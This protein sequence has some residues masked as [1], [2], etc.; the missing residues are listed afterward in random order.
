MKKNRIENIM[1]AI[2]VLAAIGG[3]VFF[4][5]NLAIGFVLLVLMALMFISVVFFSFW[6]HRNEDNLSQPRNVSRWAILTTGF[7]AVVTMGSYF[8]PSSKKIYSNNDHHAIA[9]EGLETNQSSLL[10]AANS[11][12]ALFDN[13]TLEGSIELK[14]ISTDDSTATLVM[15]G[16]GQPVFSIKFYKKNYFIALE[17]QEHLHQFDASEGL[18]LIGIDGNTVARL[19]I[20]YFKKWEKLKKRWK[21]NYILEYLGADGIMHADTSAYN[22]VILKR[23]SLASLFPGIEAVHGVDFS[24]IDLVRSKTTLNN[25]IK[26][27]EAKDYPF[28]VAYNSGSGLSALRSGDKT[29]QIGRRTSLKIKLDNSAYAIGLDNTIPQFRLCSDTTG[30]ASVRFRMPQYRYL[31]TE[32]LKE[33]EDDYFTFMV[34]STLIDDAGNINEQL[35][36]N[37]LLY[38]MFDHVDNG[39]QMRPMYMSFH[40]GNTR[41][42]LQVKV[43]DENGNDINVKAGENM[44][45]IATKGGLARWIVSLDNFKDPTLQRPYLIKSPLSAKKMLLYIIAFTLVCYF[46]MLINYHERTSYM[47]PMVYI[48]IITLLAIRLM[49]MWRISVFPPTNG[50]TLEEFNSWRTAGGLISKITQCIIFFPLA[51]L[52]YKLLLLNKRTAQN[53]IFERWNTDENNFWHLLFPLKAKRHWT[54]V[55]MILAWFVV[56][57]LGKLLLTRPWFCVGFTVIYYFVVDYLIHKWLGSRATDESNNSYSFFWHSLINSIF[58]SGAMLI[59]DGGYGIMFLIFTMLLIGTRLIDLYGAN[60]YDKIS[61]A[62]IHVYGV[63]IMLIIVTLILV[64]IRPVI[65][66]IYI[67]GTS[68]IVVAAVATAA[69]CTLIT[70]TVGGFRRFVKQSFIVI[71][72][73]AAIASGV[74]YVM[75]NYG[76]DH[77]ANRAK[78]LEYE[79]DKILGQ[80]SSTKD[81]QKFLEAS[82]ND[83]VLEEYEERGHDMAAFIG[84]KGEGYFKI[85]PHSKVGVSWMTQ[86][87]DLSVSRFMIA[88]QSSALPIL[89]IA[90]FALLTLFSMLVPA[91]RRWARSLLVQIPLLLTTQSLFVWMAVTRRFIFMGQDFPMI[92]IISRVN[93]YMCFIG[94]LVWICVAMSERYFLHLQEDRISQELANG[95]TKNEIYRFQIRFS[96]I[97][98]AFLVI[99]GFL[100]VLFSQIKGRHTENTYNVKD[101][102][103]AAYNLIAHPDKNSVEALFLEYQD[104]LISATNDSLNTH[105]RIHDITKLGNHIAIVKSFCRHLNYTPGQINTSGLIDR[106]FDSDPTYGTF[107]KA[108]FDHY[109]EKQ[110]IHNDIDDF[111]YVVKYRYTDEEDPKIENVRYVFDLYTRIYVQNLPTRLEHSWRGSILSNSTVCDSVPM[112]ARE[113]GTSIY[114]LPSNWIKRHSL[115]VRP[116]SARLSVV[117]K[118]EPRHLA[119]GEAYNLT[120]GETL[121]GRGAPDLTKYGSGNYIARNV[122][123]NS[124]A[125]FIYPLQSY[126]YWANPIS[127]QLK[128]YMNA[129]LA[130]EKFHNKDN[131]NKSIELTISASLTKN[132]YQEINN[133]GRTNG[134]VAVVVADGNGYVRALIDHKKKEYDINPNDSRRIQQVE[135]SLKREGMLNRGLEAQR[136]FGNKAILSL[137]NGPG[138]SQKPLVWTAVTTQYYTGWDWNNLQLAKINNSLM[139]HGEK[140]NALSWAG[141]RID[142]RKKVAN[143]TERGMFRSITGDEG[144]GTSNV[145]IQS[146]MKYSSN[147]YNA[148]MTH[149]GSF[150]REE[151]DIGTPQSN[152]IFKRSNESWTTDNRDDHKTIY[153]DS[154]FPLMIYDNSYLIFTNP[155]DSR[156]ATEQEAV[157]VKGLRDNF[158]LPTEYHKRDSNTQNTFHPFLTGK[159]RNHYAYPEISF[160]NNKIRNGLPFEIAR[161]GVKMTAIGK[162]SVWLV[163]PFTMAEMYG[164]MI[165]FNRN[166]RLTI[167]SNSPVPPYSE[168]VTED[169]ES[170]NYLTMRNRKFIPGLNSVFHENGGTAKSVFDKINNVGNYHIYGK[171]GTINGKVNGKDQEDHLLAVII[172]NKDLSLISEIKDYHNLKF[173]VIYIAD[174]NYANDKM[175]WKDNDA[176][177][178]NTVLQ[179]NEFKQYMKGGH[180]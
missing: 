70:W 86:L 54:L 77:I 119:S 136:F 83:W 141:Q 139:P 93:T 98:F 1:L 22:S 106:I 130:K 118:Y 138:S 9:I 107:A 131:V 174:F 97:E 148:I 102:A 103:D 165:S 144:G 2:I 90:M 25:E 110:I 36:E 145:D 142:P 180:Q 104:S 31:S 147:Y 44:P 84:E 66:S 128:G 45:R 5:I 37:I 52:L 160:F 18:E 30:M 28:I 53:P 69:I 15:D 94:F 122:I 13:K 16:F 82:L 57:P 176:R 169:G 117:G 6:R 137:D 50:I 75:Q 108:A 152:P 146:Y 73:V 100:I 10:L 113:E 91:D 111:I 114:T 61:K 21:A 92:S 173:Y 85:Q 79:P 171:T 167:D 74:T 172:T 129:Q 23:Y 33:G 39:N 115:I 24:K 59:C 153:I 99:A 170:S 32:S 60:S 154:I 143:E 125:E 177:I 112:L 64:Y 166:Y 43:L 42:P 81:M 63:L 96:L 162:N 76:G 120:E 163:S 14:D 29:T 34:A 62:G 65:T 168:F 71:A 89:L 95:D 121:I 134:N 175:S 149:I 158:S 4:A 140:Y 179:S 133:N 7:I 116:A 38:E 27:K 87:S 19:Y 127:Q 132:L 40:R 17:G 78:V 11:N 159:I 151:L 72:L 67:G 157:L 135:D 41:T 47:E 58:A 20:N 150:T 26:A 101:C 161:E 126:F 105:Q 51:L 109:L 164:K 55:I 80:A 46:I 48:A 124:R 56:A 156:H 68:A 178:I 35:A 8:Y 123:I 49:L 88:E 3:I 12:K 155:L